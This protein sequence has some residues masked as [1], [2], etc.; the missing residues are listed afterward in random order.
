M[1]SVT[2]RAAKAKALSAAEDE[3]SCGRTKLAI[4][5]AAATNGVLGGAKH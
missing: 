4:A 3:S 5:P 1:A 2:L